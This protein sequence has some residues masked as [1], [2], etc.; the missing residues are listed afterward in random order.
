MFKSGLTSYQ[1]KLIMAFVMVLDHI[2][3]MFYYAGAPM[4]LTMLGRLVMPVFLFMCAEGYYHTSNKKKYTIRLY[5]SFLLMNLGNFLIMHFFPMM[6]PNQ[7]ILVNN[8]FGT[9]LLSVVAMYGADLLAEKKA[10]SIVKGLLVLLLPAL[11]GFVY[12]VLLMQGF[13]D[14]A[15]VSMVIPTYMTVEGGYLCVFLALAFYLFRNRPWAQYLVLVVVSFLATGLSF[16]GLFEANI[17][18]MMGFAILPL[19]LYNGQRGKGSK[20]FFYWFYPAHIYILYLLSYF[21][22]GHFM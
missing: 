4:W 2:H 17:Q 3:Q 7:V 1:L 15:F 14:V 13:Y 6:D 22:N 19:M 8:V 12:I 18:W 10:V 9:M 16:E 20:Y 11:L 21:Y 5:L